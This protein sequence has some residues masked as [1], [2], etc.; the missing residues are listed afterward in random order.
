MGRPA[1]TRHTSVGECVFVC[2]CRR[3]QNDRVETA[4]AGSRRLLVV[5]VFGL[6]RLRALACVRF[7]RTA[8]R[9][10]VVHRRC[11]MCCGWSCRVHWHSLNLH[12]SPTH[13]HAHL[14][15]G[16]KLDRTKQ[17]HAHT[18]AESPTN[19]SEMSIC[20]VTTARISGFSS[21]DH[22]QQTHNI[23]FPFACAHSGQ[24]TH[25]TCRESRNP[26]RL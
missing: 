26:F 20:R 10:S 4:H 18:D 7:F 24:H 21:V 17:T 11:C 2:V 22:S 12:S 23:L 13:T 1:V 5:C 6:I 14:S 8:G 16:P 3:R 25:H 19:P 15:L 9:R